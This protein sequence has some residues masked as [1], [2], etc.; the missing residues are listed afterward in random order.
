MWHAGVASI[1]ITTGAGS[2][3]DG[4]GY[5]L[6][7]LAYALL[8]DQDGLQVSLHIEVR[9]LGPEA[10]EALLRGRS[11]GKVEPVAGLFAFGFE[12]QPSVRN[13]R[14]GELVAYPSLVAHFGEP[15][16]DYQIGPLLLDVVYG[17]V[18]MQ[19]S[20]LVFKGEVCP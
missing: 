3:V 12:T 15:P 16:G 1:R 11:M 4:P 19:L 20:Y 6:L 18:G 17:L 10:E 5:G 13:G 8:P 7:T 9:K 14:E 2:S